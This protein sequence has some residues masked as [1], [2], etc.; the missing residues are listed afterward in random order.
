M[1]PPHARDLLNPLDDVFHRV[2]EDN[3]DDGVLVVGLNV[4]DD[5]SQ[6]EELTY[7][8]DEI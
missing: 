2:N 5:S 4:N 7:N 6:P 1:D 8:L 3:E